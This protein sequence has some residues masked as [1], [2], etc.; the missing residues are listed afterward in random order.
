VIDIDIFG[1]W[2]CCGGREV[3]GKM[4]SYQFGS[5]CSVV[6]ILRIIALSIMLLEESQ[7]DDFIQQR[8]FGPRDSIAPSWKSK[9]ETI[10]TGLL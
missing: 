7:D 1:L 4:T 9:G 6:F 2:I 10:E 5:F 8:E 3:K